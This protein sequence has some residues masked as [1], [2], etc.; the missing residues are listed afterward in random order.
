MITLLGSGVRGADLGLRAASEVSTEV[1]NLAQ[2]YHPL[3]QVLAFLVSTT[4]WLFA[5]PTFAALAAGA[6]YLDGVAP[7]D[8]NPALP[9]LMQN[10]NQALEGNGGNDEADADH[11][12]GEDRDGDGNSVER[13]SNNQGVPNMENDEDSSDGGHENNR[14]GPSGGGGR[15]RGGND[16]AEE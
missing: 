15:G 10:P 3:L 9:S 11:A 8:R 4:V 1:M 14:G 7:C 6:L 2:G 5:V 16:D 12:D 13:D